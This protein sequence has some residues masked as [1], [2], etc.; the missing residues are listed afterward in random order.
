[1]YNLSSYSQD[2]AENNVR[3]YDID[4]AYNLQ[5]LN[6]TDALGYKNLLERSSASTPMENA[7]IA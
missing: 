5:D 7:N 4:A 1:M 6:N 3:K 2:S